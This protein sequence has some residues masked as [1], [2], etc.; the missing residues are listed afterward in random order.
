MAPDTVAS[1]GIRADAV[2]GSAGHR[3]INGSVNCA[4]SGFT[5]GGDN[6]GQWDKYFEQPLAWLIHVVPHWVLQALKTFTIE[7]IPQVR[8]QYFP[9]PAA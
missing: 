7:R 3:G 2:K 6:S 8:K 1:N 4:G 5:A 9:A